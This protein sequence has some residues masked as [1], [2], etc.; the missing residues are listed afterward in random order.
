MKEWNQND[1]KGE[2]D[3]AASENPITE[4]FAEEESHKATGLHSA[5]FLDLLD[6][7]PF[8]R[9]VL[10]GLDSQDELINEAET[11][12]GGFSDGKTSSKDGSTE[13]KLKEECGNNDE[14]AVE[15]CVS[16][17]TMKLTYNFEQNIEGE[18]TGEGTGYDVRNSTASLLYESHISTGESNELA[19]CG[20]GYS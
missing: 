16:R 18:N 13:R 6:N 5:G 19:S 20:L 3:I 14:K 1:W 12:V 4:A 11:T 2:Q 17:L 15:S 7:G 10:D 8:P 9:V